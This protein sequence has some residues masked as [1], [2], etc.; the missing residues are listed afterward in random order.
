VIVPKGLPE[1]ALFQGS[2]GFVDKDGNRIRY[3]TIYSNAYHG[4]GGYPVPE[5]AAGGGGAGAGAGGQGPGGRGVP[6]N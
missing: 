5:R 6:P 3:Q 1:S 2:V 4:L